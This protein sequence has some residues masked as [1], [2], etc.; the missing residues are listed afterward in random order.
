MKPFNLEL[1]KAGYPVCTRDGRDARIICFDRSGKDFY[2]IVALVK[3]DGVEAI[4]LY[5]SNGCYHKND[6]CELDLFMK[7]T[8]KEGWINIYKNSYGEY[9]GHNIYSSENNAI[10][11]VNPNDRHIAT[12]KIEW[13]E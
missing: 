13:E 4:R 9:R 3:I 12:I 10:A 11:G 2:P 8:K 6:F 5:T 1:A 7:S